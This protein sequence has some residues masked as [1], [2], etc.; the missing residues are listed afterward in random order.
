[1]IAWLKARW[2]WFVIGAVV[3]LAF[4]FGRGLTRQQVEQALALKKL[5]DVTD[6][7]LKT[8]VQADQLKRESERL[9]RELT[10]EKEQLEKEK[11]DAAKSDHGAVVLDLKR[12]RILK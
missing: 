2:Q 10:M 5:N 3:L 7:H 4:V 6:R 9:E 11:S 12:R 8:Q 1:M